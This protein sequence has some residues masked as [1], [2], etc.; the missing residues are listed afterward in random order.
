MAFL[1]SSCSLSLCTWICVHRSLRSTQVCRDAF[2]MHLG[3]RLST[4][5]TPEISAAIL[6]IAALAALIGV[7]DYANG[8]IV[9]AWHGITL[10]AVVSVLAT[11]SKMAATFLVGSAISQAKWCLFSHGPQPLQDF[12]AVDQASRGAL[13]CVSFLWK[14]RKL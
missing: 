13:G 12:E 5:W 9:H 3:G 8:T 6:S 10:N 2:N 11:I 4:G 7:L 14:R 1:K